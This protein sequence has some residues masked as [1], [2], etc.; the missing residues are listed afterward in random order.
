MRCGVFTLASRARA[1]SLGESSL[2]R[3]RLPYE[4]NRARAALCSRP[5]VAVG[6]SLL[7]KGVI[8]VSELQGKVTEVRSRLEIANAE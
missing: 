6:R 5:A 7:E 2:N 1:R 3:R 8:S 4:D